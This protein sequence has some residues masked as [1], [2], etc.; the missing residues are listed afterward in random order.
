MINCCFSIT[1]ST[2][3]TAKQIKHPRTVCSLN[4]WP[5]DHRVRARQHSQDSL[6]LTPLS[7]ALTEDCVHHQSND[8]TVFTVPGN[9]VIAA[10]ERHLVSE[11]HLQLKW[12]GKTFPNNR[13]VLWFWLRGTQ[14]L[15][16]HFCLLWSVCITKVNLKYIFVQ[17]RRDP[18][19]IHLSRLLISFQAEF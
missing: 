8:L 18:Q 17:I 7:T 16:V 10:L 1:W 19:V 6:S 4:N 11:N 15:L 12:L 13:N 14:Q 2:F 5:E 9:G 3:I